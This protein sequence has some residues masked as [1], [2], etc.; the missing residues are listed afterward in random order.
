MPSDDQ[1]SQITVENICA[2][3]DVF[4]FEEFAQFVLTRI[5]HVLQPEA[6]TANRR[7]LLKLNFHASRFLTIFRKC[8]WGPWALLQSGIGQICS[9]ICQEVLRDGKA[10]SSVPAVQT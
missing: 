1:I 9:R 3:R 2:K 4:A 10:G 8:H 6:W 5:K 7:I